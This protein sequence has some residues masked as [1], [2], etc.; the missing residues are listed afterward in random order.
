MHFV[1]FRPY[2]T[3]FPELFSLTLMLKSKKTWETSL[4]LTPPLETSVDRRRKDRVS[5]FERALFVK[6]A[7]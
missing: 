5:C 6:L 2:A 4:D 1:Q 7:L 3:S